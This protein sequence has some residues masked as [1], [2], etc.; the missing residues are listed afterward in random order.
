MLISVVR[1]LIIVVSVLFSRLLI[2]MLGMM[3][4][5]FVLVS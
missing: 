2:C 1:M 3:G 4:V 5:L